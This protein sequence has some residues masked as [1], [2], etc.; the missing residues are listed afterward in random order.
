MRA[1]IIQSSCQV[2]SISIFNSNIRSK[3]HVRKRKYIIN[4][5]K[6]TK[7]HAIV[8]LFVQLII[9]IYAIKIQWHQLCC[10]SKEIKSCKNYWNSIVESEIILYASCDRV[11]LFE[12]TL[13]RVIESCF[14]EVNNS[15]FARSITF[16]LSFVHT[17]IM[18]TSQQSTFVLKER[19]NRYTIC[20]VNW[21]STMNRVRDSKFQILKDFS[22]HIIID[23]DATLK[24]R[25]TL[26][27]FL[28]N[29]IVVINNETMTKKR[30]VKRFLKSKTKK[31]SNSFDFFLFVLFTNSTKNTIDTII[32]WRK[33]K[34]SSK[35]KNKLRELR[36]DSHA[37]FVS[38]RFSQLVILFSRRFIRRVQMKTIERFLFELNVEFRALHE[39][40]L[41]LFELS[42]NEKINE[43]S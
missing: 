19:A 43:S 3:V 21:A 41:Q 13:F 6:I 2:F 39:T 42:K 31:Q 36:V 33:L 34:K 35:A 9:I 23:D 24:T 4:F 25:V 32:A 1:L 30:K 27:R 15:R 18:I 12:S 29:V 8:A 5:I 11:L 40:S 16:T 22:N 10:E 14:N 26:K 37:L 28:Q 7:T 20:V 17:K 38:T